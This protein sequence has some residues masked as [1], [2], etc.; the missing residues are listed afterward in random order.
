[1]DVRLETQRVLRVA[2]ALDV[3]STRVIRSG[4][5]GFADARE[6][7]VEM[8][9]KGLIGFVRVANF[10]DGDPGIEDVHRGVAVHVD[11]CIVDILVPIGEAVWPP[12][13][14]GA[15]HHIAEW[16]GVDRQDAAAL[17]DRMAVATARAQRRAGTAR[18]HRDALRD[19][20]PRLVAA[21]VL[22]RPAEANE[23]IMREWAARGSSVLS[24]YFPGQVASAVVAEIG[25]EAG[26]RHG[27]SGR[28][29]ENIWLAAYEDSVD[30]IV[31]A[32]RDAPHPLERSER[33]RLTWATLEPYPVSLRLSQG[34]ILT[35]AVVKADVP[36]AEP[37]FRVMGSEVFVLPLLAH[38]RVSLAT[39]GLL[40]AERA[41]EQGIQ[42]SPWAEA[43]AAQLQMW[44]YWSARGA[45]S[46]PADA[47][48]EPYV[49]DA[50]V[51]ADVRAFLDGDA[52]IEVPYGDIGLAER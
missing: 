5:F 52:T 42:T 38:S 43:T 11:D 4:V 14:V 49:D 30:R 17:H 31:A 41:N 34:R 24:A 22:E 1:M 36:V 40:A 13:G 33:Q 28:L 25:L 48:F 10:T 45:T 6:E 27:F 18:R 51:C 50:E 2:D 12:P 7:F 32:I 37:F 23:L 19:Q 44:E 20:L 21:R 26:L 15:V 39:S 16:V 3:E 29:S 9:H 46:R 47:L 8:S 35:S